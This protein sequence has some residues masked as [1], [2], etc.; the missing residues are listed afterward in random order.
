MEE[1]AS[2]VSEGGNAWMA[3]GWVSSAMIER[4][5]NWRPNLKISDSEIEIFQNATVIV[6]SSSNII[7]F[8]FDI[9]T[10]IKLAIK[11]YNFR[12]EHIYGKKCA[13]Y[14]YNN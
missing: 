6:D 3:K 10:M 5:R 8:P 12:S 11:L 4:E 14:S 7:C 9:V 2:F 13:W 1:Q